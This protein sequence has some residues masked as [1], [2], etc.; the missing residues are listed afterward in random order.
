MNARI[1]RGRFLTLAGLLLLPL[2]AR[3]QVSDP[4]E[5]L[6]KKMMEAIRARSYDDFM[7]EV[8]ETMRAALTKQQFDG[9]CGL[10]AASL[11]PGY[12]TTYL[13][14][15]QQKG[16]AIYLWKLVPATLKDDETLIR[17]A[18]KDK[19]VSGFLLQ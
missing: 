19:K 11:Q 9:V 5:G 2:S 15:L 17:I 1:S 14:K 16:H 8:D 18:I 10:M 13:G 7:I 12:K 3:A 4:P 6:M